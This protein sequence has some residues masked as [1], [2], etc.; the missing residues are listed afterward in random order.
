LQL[1]QDGLGCDGFDHKLVRAVIPGSGN[2]LRRDLQA[3]QNHRDKRIA[4]VVAVA[5]LTQQI[6]SLMR[7]AAIQIHKHQIHGMG[8]KRPER[9]GRVGCFKNLLR[10]ALQQDIAQHPAMRQMRIGNQHGQGMKAVARCHHDLVSLG[11][12]V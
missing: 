4:A 12:K 8:F 3:H 6:K 2:S 1:A 10:A 7:P 11:L 5:Q 9:L